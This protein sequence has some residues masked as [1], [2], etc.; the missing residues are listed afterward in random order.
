MEEALCW[1]GQA[2]GWKQSGLSGCCM[3][4]SCLEEF[5]KA[6][7]DFAWLRNKPW[8]YQ[9]TKTVGLFVTQPNQAY[10]A[11]VTDWYTHKG[12]RSKAA[13]ELSGTFSGHFWQK[14]RSQTTV[15]SAR[16]RKKREQTDYISYSIILKLYEQSVTLNKSQLQIVLII[17]IDGTEHSN[18]LLFL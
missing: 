17:K 14:S 15:G 12:T 6:M 7:V 3:G 5:P 18:V 2:S 11:L 8:W 16:L 4:D 1:H 10:G 13:C 9:A